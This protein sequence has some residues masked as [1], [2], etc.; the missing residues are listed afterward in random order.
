MNS[1]QK[2]TLNLAMSAVVN[3]ISH[4]ER[5]DA[6][7]QFRRLAADIACEIGDDVSL[8]V[9]IME[10]GGNPLDKADCQRIIDYFENQ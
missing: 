10:S 6:S 7:N 4:Q 8:M 1:N 2:A 3:A 5:R 9:S